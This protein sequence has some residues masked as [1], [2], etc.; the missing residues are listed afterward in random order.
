MKVLVIGNSH[1]GAVKLGWD[2]TR[3]PGIEVD[4]LAVPGGGGPWYRYEDGKLAVYVPPG[5]SM[6]TTIEGADPGG[7][8]IAAYD[9]QATQQRG[10][11]PL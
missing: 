4:F 8:D 11:A 3:R 7:T 6:F 1:V 9:G 2:A 10:D 5:R